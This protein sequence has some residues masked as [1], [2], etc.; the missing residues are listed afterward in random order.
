M[1]I[2][3]A[4]PID[5]RRFFPMNF[6]RTCQFRDVSSCFCDEEFAMEIN[7]SQSGDPL[8]SPTLNL[9]LISLFSNNLER[10]T[11]SRLLKSRRIARIVCK[12]PFIVDLHGKEELQTEILILVSRGSF[13]DYVIIQF[14]KL[15]ENK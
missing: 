4:S 14:P 3:M 13:R 6:F 2:R 7:Q 12:D 8:T 10:D 9:G 11:H 5:T 15:P 1:R